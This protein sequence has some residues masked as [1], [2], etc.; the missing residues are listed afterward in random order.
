MEPS[1]QAGSN[2]ES[3]K[4]PH[5]TENVIKGISL[6]FN[7]VDVSQFNANK[8]LSETRAEGSEKL[9][10]ESAKLHKTKENNT[11]NKNKPLLERPQ[12]PFEDTQ[13]AEAAYI[14]NKPI[15]VNT[16]NERERII[17]NSIK[18]ELFK[19][20]PKAEITL[21]DEELLKPT[22][23]PAKASGSKYTDIFG[24]SSG[25]DEDLFGK[26]SKLPA[27]NPVEKRILSFVTESDSDGDLFAGKLPQTKSI[28]QAKPTQKK[29]KSW[30]FDDS[31]GSSDD[32]LFGI[33][34]KNTSI[35]SDTKGKF[36][37]G[38]LKFAI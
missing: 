28:S 12:K 36:F 37:E 34:T 4:T 19:H 21:P 15:V 14:F 29:E 25:S 11:P 5:S 23:L 6:V 24:D 33:K 7:Q 27:V 9:F 35:P 17:G 30:I 20:T 10:G 38:F 2:K 16:S 32:D 26:S 8:E 22:D 31:E 18:D 3:S 1:K 13:R